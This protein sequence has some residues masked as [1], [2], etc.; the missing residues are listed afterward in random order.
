MIHDSVKIIA[1]L[2]NSIRYLLQRNTCD[3]I[4]ASFAR[5]RDKDKC[6]CQVLVVKLQIAIATMESVSGGARAVD[7]H[8][9]S[10]L[11][12]EGAYDNI[13]IHFRIFVP[14]SHPLD[15]DSDCEAVVCLTEKLSSIVQCIY[16]QEHVP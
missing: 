14:K 13:F 7:G 5:A 9:F 12:H 10:S 11:G 16:G 6:V 8:G 15:E 4:L 3:H 1:Y 2:P